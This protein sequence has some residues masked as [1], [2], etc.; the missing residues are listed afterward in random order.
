MCPSLVDIE[1]KSPFTVKYTSADRFA[2]MHLTLAPGTKFPEHTLRNINTGLELHIGDLMASESFQ[3][4]ELSSAVPQYILDVAVM[5]LVNQLDGFRDFIANHRA[6]KGAKSCERTGG[7]LRADLEG[8]GTVFC[9]YKVSKEHQT[10][11]TPPAWQK[12][13][14]QTGEI[15]DFSDWSLGEIVDTPEFSF[16]FKQRM[17]PESANARW[18]NTCARAREREQHRQQTR[19]VEFN[20][21]D[22]KAAECSSPDTNI[23]LGGS[24]AEFM[25]ALV[26]LDR[27]LGGLGD[28]TTS[29]ADEFAESA[30]KFVDAIAATF[31]STHL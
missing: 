25:G 10:D 16:S 30:D 20:L 22:S 1:L 26:K 21:G 27:V 24:A 3:S 8:Y 6:V 9:Q 7:S 2:D 14:L 12:F 19:R 15:P 29:L 13:Q 28:S 18:Q 11:G 31:G 4:D 17:H 23:A 5:I